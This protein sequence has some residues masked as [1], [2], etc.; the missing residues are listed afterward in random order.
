MTFCLCNYYFKHLQGITHS[1]ALIWPWVIHEITFTWLLVYQSGYYLGLSL[2]YYF[3]L[4]KLLMALS[5]LSTT[6]GITFASPVTYNSRYRLA[7]SFYPSL[8]TLCYLHLQPITWSTTLTLPLTNHTWC[9]YPVFTFD[10]FYHS[11]ISV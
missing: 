4:T 1:I 8:M 3:G 9:Y 5:W 7:I 6:H 2:I 10:H 11:I